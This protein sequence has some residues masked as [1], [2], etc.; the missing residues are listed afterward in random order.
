MACLSPAEREVDLLESQLDG[1]DDED[2]KRE[3]RQQ[4]REIAQYEAEREEWENRGM[5]EGWL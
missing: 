4:L 5:D 3:I 1:A 2:E